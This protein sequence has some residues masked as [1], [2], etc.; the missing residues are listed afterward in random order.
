MNK[1]SKN[2]SRLNWYYWLFLLFQAPM[3]HGAARIGGFLHAFIYYLYYVLFTKNLFK[4]FFACIYLL[5]LYSLHEV[6][7]QIFHSFFPLVFFFLLFSLRLLVL[8]YI[9]VCTYFL[10]V[11]GVSFLFL[12]GNFQRDKFLNLVK[13]HYWF[14]CFLTLWILIS[15]LK[16]N[17]AQPKVSKEFLLSFLMEIL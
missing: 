14:Y 7:I 16:E 17:F 10:P 13:L 3:W 9:C 2:K 8:H 6:S 1:V 15:M 11:C 5:P 12:N 4:S